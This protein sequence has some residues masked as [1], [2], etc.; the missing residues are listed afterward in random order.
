MRRLLRNARL[1]DGRHVD[2]EVDDGRIAR[3]T[4]VDIARTGPAGFAGPTGTGAATSRSDVR[5]DRHE[6]HQAGDDRQD[7]HQAGDDRR[8]RG[9]REAPEVDDLGG[10]LVLG[11]FAEPHAHLDKALTAEAVPN[12]SGDLAGAIAAWNHAAAQ[13]TFGHD[14]TVARAVA[15]MTALVRNGCTH[16]R[17]HA[18][19]GGAAAHGAAAAGRT[20]CLASKP[21]Q[22]PPRSGNPLSLQRRPAAELAFVEARHPAQAGLKRCDARAEFMAVQ[23]QDGCSPPKLCRVLQPPRIRLC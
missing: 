1:A 18:N 21:S 19:V 13:G 10:R 6:Q 23:R 12:P 14:D 22:Q 7:E 16:V 2:I 17:T 15:A 20:P 3:I 8:A 5:D 9:E 4:P 11:A